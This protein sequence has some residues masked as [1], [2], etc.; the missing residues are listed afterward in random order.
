MNDNSLDTRT[1][2]ESCIDLDR[3]RDPGLGLDDRIGDLA[4]KQAR[5]SGYIDRWWDGLSVR[6]LAGVL[7]VHGRNGV[8]L[9]EL[10]RD[11]RAVGGL[12]EPGV[13]IDEVIADLDAKLGRLSRSIDEQWPEL[14]SGNVKPWGRLVTVYSQNCVHLGQ[15]MRVRRALREERSS[16][17]LDAEMDAALDWLSRDWG[18]EL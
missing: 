9:G 8:R 13:C 6:Q 1:S 18:V 16:D 12:G 17:E 5:F 14:D 15:L 4:D 7:K 3:D 11:W 10:L 2:R